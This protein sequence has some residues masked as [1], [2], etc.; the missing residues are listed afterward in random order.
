MSKRPSTTLY[1]CCASSDNKRRVA[2]VET[3]AKQGSDL[4]TVIATQA[5]N[6]PSPSD[7]TGRDTA[8]GSSVLSCDRPGPS[9]RHRMLLLTEIMAVSVFSLPLLLLLVLGASGGW[10]LSF[11]FPLRRRWSSSCYIFYAR[12]LKSF[13]RTG[14]RIEINQCQQALSASFGFGF[15]SLLF[16]HPPRPADLVVY[17]STTAPLPFL[18]SVV[19]SLPRLY[20]FVELATREI[21]LGRHT[22][23][24]PERNPPSKKKIPR[25]QS[26]KIAVAH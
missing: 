13:M 24:H 23:E 17:I 10:V 19:A 1:A 14:M 11:G 6:I 12:I 16:G 22:M 18:S 15:C 5:P 3:V 9:G 21:F 25:R 7:L 20:L 26:Q 4:V 8:V 2:V